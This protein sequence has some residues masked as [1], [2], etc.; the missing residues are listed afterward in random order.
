MT[1]DQTPVYAAVV[2]LWDRPTP[3]VLLWLL[4]AALVLLA[5]RL[6]IAAT[7]PQEAADAEPA[8]DHEE[9]TAWS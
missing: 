7:A 5:V 4:V 3:M 6:F 9:V 1:T 8:K 2:V